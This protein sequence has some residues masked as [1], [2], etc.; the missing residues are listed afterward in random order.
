M[1]QG[2]IG[3]FIAD[4]RRRKGLTQMQLAERMNVTDR[5]VSKWENGRSLPD[6]SIMLALCHLLDISVND[7]LHGEVVMKESYHEKTEE[8]LVEMAKQKEEA[9]RKM[10]SLEIVI[11]VLSVIVLLGAN[12]VAAYLPMAAWLQITL[13]A[14]GFAIGLIGLM[15]ALRIEQTAGYYECAVCH[16]KYVPGFWRVL[17]AMHMGRTR[18]MRC[19]HCGKRSWQKK[20]VSKD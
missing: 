16:H 4:R 1:D 9:D 13:A 8:L 6:A 12:C 17:L 10:L 2:K 11:G 15:L 7:L 19:P 5:A 18:Y 3:R 14:S 20:R